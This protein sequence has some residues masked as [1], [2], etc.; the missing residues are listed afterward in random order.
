MTKTDVINTVAPSLYR[1]GMALL[2]G[3]VNIVTSDGPAGRAGFTASAVCSV[4]DTPPTLLVCAKEDSS[5]GRA[6]MTNRAICVNTIGPAHEALAIRFGGKTPAEERF[7][8]AEWRTGVSGAPVLPGALVSFVGTVVKSE[9]IGT[10]R[11]LFCQVQDIL[12]SEQTAASVYFAR[13]F[14]H[15]QV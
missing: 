5:I 2:A 4:C 1:D 13:K 8:T 7:A 9:R 3:A 11:V 10:H 12:L 6:F 15:V 14:H